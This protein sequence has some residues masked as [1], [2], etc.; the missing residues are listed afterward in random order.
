MNGLH[1]IRYPTG[2]YGFAGKV[3]ACLAFDSVHADDLETAARSG[4][5]IARLIA[6]REGRSFT[7]L[8]WASSEEAQAYAAARGFT[9][10]SKES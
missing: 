8:S 3:P 4:P 10:T 7:S 9:V 6:E 2:R 1:V 5:R